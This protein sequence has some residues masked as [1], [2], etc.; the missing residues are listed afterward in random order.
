LKLG[1]IEFVSAHI[2]RV[3]YEEHM[4]LTYINATL[5]DRNYYLNAFKWL[6]KQVNKTLIMIVVT[7][8]MTWAKEN[9]AK[10]RDDIF[11]PGLFLIFQGD[12]NLFVVTFSQG[13]VSTSPRIRT[14]RCWRL[15]ITQF[16]PTELLV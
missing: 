1:E 16:L 12:D 15:V 11:M 4:N 5:V 2:R 6:Q 7:D 3:G 10:G 8:D 13:L 9:L 14:W